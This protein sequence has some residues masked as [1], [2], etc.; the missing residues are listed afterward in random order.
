M[1]AYGWGEFCVEAVSFQEAACLARQGI[2]F[3]ACPL[4]L[5]TSESLE[6]RCEAARVG[7]RSFFL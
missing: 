2:G 7:G 3:S 4:T 6:A 5:P 1:A